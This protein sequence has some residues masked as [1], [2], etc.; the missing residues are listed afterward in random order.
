M[1]PVGGMA[2]PAAGINSCAPTRPRPVEEPPALPELSQKPPPATLLPV[3]V[4]AEHVD[5]APPGPPGVPPPQYWQPQHE[6]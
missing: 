2:A 6:S 4:H 3:V 5:A 1:V